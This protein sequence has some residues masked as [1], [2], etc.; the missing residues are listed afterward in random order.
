M[1]NGLDGVHLRLIMEHCKKGEGDCDSDRDCAR[2]LRCAHDR[3]RIPGVRN[4][5]AIKW[6]RDFCYDPN[7]STLDGTDALTFL[8]GS[9][10]DRIVE[11]KSNLNQA[12]QAGVF[13]R[14]GNN[15][16][17]TKKAYLH[18][19]F[20]YWTFIRYANRS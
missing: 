16:L 18:E 13:Y 17:L 10:Y 2:G 20:P 4:T 15:R 8:N 9:N 12:N 11:T 14:A 7:D 3:M 19:N 6:G 5:G 1:L